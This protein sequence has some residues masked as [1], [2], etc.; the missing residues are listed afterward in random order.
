MLARLLQQNAT[1]MDTHLEESQLRRCDGNRCSKIAAVND[2]HCWDGASGCYLLSQS[3]MLGSYRALDLLH[4]PASAED[5]L[6]DLPSFS[7]WGVVNPRCWRYV[8][9]RSSLRRG[10]AIA[11]SDERLQGLTHAAAQEWAHP[12]DGRLRRTLRVVVDGR[13][14]PFLLQG[15]P[16]RLAQGRMVRE[17]LATTVIDGTLERRAFV[18]QRVIVNGDAAAEALAHTR[19]HYSSSLNP[20]VQVPVEAD[21]AGVD[22]AFS[23]PSII[24]ELRA[25]ARQRRRITAWRLISLNVAVLVLNAAMT[26]RGV[27]VWQ[28]MQQLRVV[29]WVQRARPHVDTTLHAMRILNWATL[30]LRLPLKQIRHGRRRLVWVV[31]RAFNRARSGAWEVSVV[32]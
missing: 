27:A 12:I 17:A 20:L 10:P 32:Q 21:A 28:L 8:K 30:P 26:A 25:E 16:Q 1:G 19:N 5:R 31:S 9:I 7:L 24:A 11:P 23:Q 2:Q 13:C 18:V 4:V 3:S 6:S 15:M 29:E 14:L 22:A